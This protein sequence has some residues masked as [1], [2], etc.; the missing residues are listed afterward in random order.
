MI[1]YIN[2]SNI[3]KIITAD[4]RKIFP[5]TIVIWIVPYFQQISI[6][7]YETSATS[8][9]LLTSRQFANR[10]HRIAGF[11]DRGVVVETAPFPMVRSP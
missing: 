6:S 9:Q 10:A 3:L 8:L 11:G 7:F 5:N 4:Y 2:S 1:C